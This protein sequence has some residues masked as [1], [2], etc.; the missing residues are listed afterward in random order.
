MVFTSLV[1][2]L[3]VCAPAIEQSTALRVIAAESG[4]RQFAININGG[5]RLSRQPSNY[6]EFREVVMALELG[7]YNFDF[8]FAQANN[9]EIKRRGHSVDQFVDPC[10]NLRFMQ[11]VLVDCFKGAA[12]A[13][14]QKRIASALSCYNTGRYGHG[15]TNGYVRRVWQVSTAQAKHAIAHVPQDKLPHQLKEKL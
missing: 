9:R 15:F 11:T 2:L 6:L 14:E 4:A 5:M 12:V 3:P 8:G 1:A 13:D 10:N 7:G